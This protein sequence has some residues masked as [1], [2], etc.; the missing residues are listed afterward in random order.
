MRGFDGQKESRW[1]SSSHHPPLPTGKSSTNQRALTFDRELSRSRWCDR[2][3]LRQ[4]TCFVALEGSF[5]RDKMGNIVVM[6]ATDGTVLVSFLWLAAQIR[7]LRPSIL[8]LLIPSLLPRLI[9]LT[10]SSPLPSFILHI[11]IHTRPDSL[12]PCLIPCFLLLLSTLPT[13]SF[14]SLDSSDRLPSPPLLL[15]LLWGF[16]CPRPR[17]HTLS[18]PFPFLPPL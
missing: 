9:L 12:D 2:H 11:V 5:V 17:P 3:A 4:Q 1:D 6:R 13:D 16:L 10:S 7:M 18:L 14:S 8:P 15:R